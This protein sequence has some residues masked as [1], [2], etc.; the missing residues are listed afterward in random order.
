VSE[1][2]VEHDHP[3]EDKIGLVEKIKEKLPGHHDEKAEDSPAVT[4]TPLVVTEHPAVIN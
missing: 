3:E 4:S 1:S 2:V